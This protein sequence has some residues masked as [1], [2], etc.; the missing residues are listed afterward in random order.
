MK[1]PGVDVKEPSASYCSTRI[2]D[3]RVFTTQMAVNKAVRFVNAFGKSVY[4]K[5][6]I[7]G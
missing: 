1:I 7:Y 3:E 6:W 4:K 5:R 2:V